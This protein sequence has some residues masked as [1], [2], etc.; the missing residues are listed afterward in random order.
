MSRSLTQVFLQL[1]QLVLNCQCYFSE[2]LLEV[3]PIFA[4]EQDFIGHRLCCDHGCRK[5]RHSVSLWYVN[6]QNSVIN[7]HKS[8]AFV[9]TNNELSEKKI[10]GTIPFM[11]RLKRMKYHGI[12]LMMDVQD[13]YSQ[14]YKHWWGELKMIKR[15]GKIS[16][17]PWLEGLMLLKMAIL[18]KAIYR[19]NVMTD[20][21]PRT[22][23]QK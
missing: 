3:L 2:H 5:K 10:Q 15:N 4:S 1:W 12:N 8:V 22:L 7:L 9:Y 19:F 21:I 17:V 6:R 11:I 14:K 18:S 23:L 20:K 16:R 13:L